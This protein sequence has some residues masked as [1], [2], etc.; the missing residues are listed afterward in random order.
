MDKKKR[1][2]LI[3]GIVA[4]TAVIGILFYSFYHNWNDATCE[5]PKTCS[6]CGKTEGEPLGH[7]WEKATCEEPKT[8][9]VCGK[10]EGEPLGHK[11]EKATCEEPKTCSV[12]KETEGKPLGHEVSEWK[13]VKEPTCVEEGQ[14]EAVCSRCNQ[15]ISESIDKTEHTAGDWEVKTDYVI[16]AQALITPGEEVK[17]CTVCGKQLESREYTV[18][19]S[20]SQRNAILKAY[21][22]LNSWHCGRDYLINEILVSSE[23]FPIEDATFAVDH[24]KVDWEEQAI[25]YAKKDGIGKSEKQLTEDLIY[26]GFNQDQIKKALSAVG[27]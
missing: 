14:K 18:E 7:K 13:V 26:Y 2:I 10:T 23:G 21:Q 6:I 9:S 24:M 25:L 17:K 27:Y 5:T 20:T 1:N 22:K 3:I 12:C 8:C 4:A 15:T 16:S 19:L 11:W